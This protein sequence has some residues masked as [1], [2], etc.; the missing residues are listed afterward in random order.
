MATSSKNDKNK[1]KDKN[2]AS[3]DAVYLDL[4]DGVLTGAQ[5]TQLASLIT[6][7]WGGAIGD[8]QAVHFWRDGNTIRFSV[9]GEKQVAPAS[10]PKRGD[11]KILRWLP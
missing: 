2:V 7:I 6:S 11:L 5:R 4:V 8:V 10:L 1:Q 9:E 3:G